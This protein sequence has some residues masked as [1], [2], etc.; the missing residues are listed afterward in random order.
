[1]RAHDYFECMPELDNQIA[2]ANPK[3]LLLDWTRL[4]GWDKDTVSVVFL[5]RIDYR[6]KFERIAVLADATWTSEIGDLE[7]AT[8]RPVRRFPTSDQQSA[9]AWLDAI[10]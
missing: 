10:S 1:M 2:Y 3:G 8:R 5:A 6:S 4:T 9:M 7:E